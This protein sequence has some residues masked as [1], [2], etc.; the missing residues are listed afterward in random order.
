MRVLEFASKLNVQ[1]CFNGEID[2]SLF[3]IVRVHCCRF[4]KLS[5]I[6]SVRASAPPYV[7]FAVFVKTFNDQIGTCFC[8]ILSARCCVVKT[9]NDEIS[10][11]FCFI[12]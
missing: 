10:T 5:L 9:L 12:L 6:K 8:F 11:R 2:R 3:L 1:L 7:L 4:V